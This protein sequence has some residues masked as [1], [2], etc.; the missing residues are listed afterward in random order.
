MDAYLFDVDGVI[1]DPVDKKITKPKLVE[2]LARKLQDGTPIALIS[3]R[4]LQFL[5]KQVVSVLEEH[6]DNHPEMDRSLLDNLFVS[7]EFGGVYLIHNQGL[8]EEKVNPDFSIPEKLRQ[9]LNAKAEEFTD[10]ALI[11]HEKRTQFTMEA[12]R[13]NDFFGKKG[14]EIAE[15]LRELAAD[16]PNLEVRFD[17]IGMNVKNKNA[18]KHYCVIQY[19]NWL[20]QKNFQVDNYLVFGDSPSDFEMGEELHQQGLP[21]TFI[22]VGD[23]KDLE[24]KKPNFKIIITQGHCDAGTLEYLQLNEY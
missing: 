2:I 8:G 16:Y 18:T 24:N 23:K 1:T 17:R 22:F 9:Q 19:Q 7:G 4:G 13:G 14:K 20:R 6:L 15:A 5:T 10:F 21:F 11:E 12:N 3:G